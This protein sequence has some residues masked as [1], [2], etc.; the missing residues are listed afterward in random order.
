MSE[1][2]DQDADLDLLER[3][4]DLLTPQVVEN[5]PPHFANI[6]STLDAKLWFLKMV[7]ESTLLSVKQTE[8]QTIIGFVFLSLE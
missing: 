2:F 5:L 4:T 1:L 6:M 8:T 3:I 7:S